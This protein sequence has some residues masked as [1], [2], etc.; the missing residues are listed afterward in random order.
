M[1]VTPRF[2]VA[3]SVF[4][5]I[6]AYLLNA[7]QNSYTHSP[8]QD[9]IWGHKSSLGKFEKLRIT[10]DIFSDHNVVRLDVNYRGENLLKI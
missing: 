8:G 1:R 2:L 6:Y 4:V 5:K 7:M 3:L 10:S 9:H